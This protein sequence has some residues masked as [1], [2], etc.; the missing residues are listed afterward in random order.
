[1]IRDLLLTIRDNV[2]SAKMKD[3]D[4]KTAFTL[5]IETANADIE[6]IN[7]L[8]MNLLPIDPSTEE[9]VPPEGIQP[10]YYDPS[11]TILYLSPSLPLFI[12][13]KSS[14]PSSLFSP[15]VPLLTPSSIL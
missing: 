12:P 10:P 7:E 2:E 6:C 1:M 13:S 9:W 8:L 11:F 4:G 15:P 14:P 5:L 3:Y